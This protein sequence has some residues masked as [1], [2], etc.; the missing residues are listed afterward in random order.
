[1]TEQGLDAA[2][3]LAEPLRRRLYQYVV[4]RGGDVSRADAANAVGERRNLV[5]FHLDKLV[6]AGLLDVTRRK[7]SGREGP[8]SGRPAKLYRRADSQLNVQLP[9]RDYETAARV[10]ADAVEQAGADNSLYAAAH[11]EGARQ[12]STMPAEDR[13]ADLGDL[14]ALLERHGYE[15]AREDPAAGGPIR[16]RNCPFHTLAREFPTLTCGMNL[17]LLRGLLSGFEGFCAR[18]EPSPDQCCVAISK[19]NKD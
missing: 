14:V 8:G 5:A 6:E 10:F 1:M 9:P 12:A 4:A 15:P 2:G 18:M 3:T 16:L 13:P 19:N 11:N 7:V 17:E